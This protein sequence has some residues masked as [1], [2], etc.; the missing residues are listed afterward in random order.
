VAIFVLKN[1]N[2][3]SKCEVQNE[4]KKT[5]GPGGGDP[6]AFK[7]PPTPLFLRG[8]LKAPLEKGGFRGISKGLE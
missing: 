2:Q 7:S 6:E 5:L 4:D 8:E 1:I 3:I